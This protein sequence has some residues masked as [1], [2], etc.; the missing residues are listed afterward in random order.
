MAHLHSGL[1]YRYFAT[2]HLAVAAGL[3]PHIAPVTVTLSHAAC[4]T[5][6]RPHIHVILLG[7][8]SWRGLFP[9]SLNLA[10]L[11]TV[12]QLCYLSWIYFLF[13]RTDHTSN[14][15]FWYVHAH[16]L[17]SCLVFCVPPSLLHST[18]HLFPLL[19]A[20]VDFSGPILS[21]AS[22]RSLDRL[23]EV[24]VNPSSIGPRHSR[25]SFRGS[26]TA[27]RPT[28]PPFLPSLHP[29]TQTLLCTGERR[30]QFR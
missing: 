27:S 6:R 8:S 28:Q 2:V 24:Y 29:L 11:A 3:A 9:I 20:L 30:L 22:R 4:P 10:D 14:F 12:L 15:S 13:R 1:F 5:P 19:S 23:G 25:R 7:R 17:S 16:R 18:L 26:P 21:C